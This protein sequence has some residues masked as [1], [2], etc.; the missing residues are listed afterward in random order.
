[1]IMKK[2]LIIS[3]GS[4]QDTFALNY[5]KEQQFNFLIAVDAGMDFLYRYN[6]IPDMMVGDFDSVN[7]KVLEAYKKQKSIKWRKFQPEKDDTDTEIAILTALEQGADEIHILGGMGSRMDHSM[8]NVCLLGLCMEKEV[9]A[10]LID[11]QNRIRLIHS[12]TILKQELQYGDFISL[13]PFMGKVKGLTLEGFKYPLFDYT[14]GEYHSIGIS[15]EIT[16]KE[17]VISLQKGILILIES[18]DE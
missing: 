16:K 3:G 8:A 4:I 10:Y 2:V 18:K 15:N 7:P 13:I 11:K 1:M 12:Q 6:M 17:A 14:M 5:I 9:P